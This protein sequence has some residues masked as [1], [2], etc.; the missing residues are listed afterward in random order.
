MSE[1]TL[2]PFTGKLDENIDTNQQ[3]ALKPFTGALDGEK[4]GVMGHLKDTGL[5]ALK[6]AVAVPE[7]AVGIMDVMSDGATGKTLEN[8][9]GTVGFRPKE[10]KQALGDLHTDQYKAQQ[11][12]FADAG[13][14]GSW[15]DKVVDKTKVAL[16]NPSLIT[17][18]V[19]ESVPSMLAGGVLG[20]AS[21]IANPVVAGAV[22]EGAV[23]AGSQA[24]QIRQET[25][26]GRL[27]ADQ[28]L[29]GAT[30][31]VLGG[32]IGFA[33]GRLAQKMGIGDVDTM[34]VTGR[35]GPAEI[36]G[37]IASMPAKSLPRR[38]VEGA[39]SEGFLE[40]L[41][42]SVS[43]QILQ[44]LALDKPWHD[45]IEDAAVMG[46]LA[47]MA[48]GGAANILSGHNTGTET[49]NNQ[50]QSSG[51]PNLPSAPPQL[52][53]SPD[54]A[55]TGEYIPRENVPQGDNQGRTAFVYD[56]PS[57][58][59]DNLL[60]NNYKGDADFDTSGNFD[61]SNNPD[62]PLSPSGGN[63]FEDN[64]TQPQLPSERLGINPDDGPMSS[65]AALAVDS[66]VTPMHSAPQD[67]SQN[68]AP[69]S[70]AIP[71]NYQSL[72]GSNNEKFTP[73]IN[74]L[75]QSAQPSER[76]T[77]NDATNNQGTN[78][79]ESSKNDG[80]TQTTEGT[81]SNTGISVSGVNKTTSAAQGQSNSNNINTVGHDSVLSSEDEAGAT[82]S[83]NIEKNASN[84]KNRT[85]EPIIGADGKNKWFGNQ[86]KAQAFID[87]KKL[88]KDYHVVQDG[89]RF[90]IQPNV[91]QVQD[92]NQSQLE[93]LEQQFVEAKTVPE[94]AK[95]RKEINALQQSVIENTISA[96]ENNISTPKN[97]ILDAQNHI[98]KSQANN[99]ADQLV[100]LEQQFLDAKSVPQKAKL[101]KQ[102]DQ[103]K[104]QQTEIT[105]TPFGSE[106]IQKQY[107]DTAESVMSDIEI[108]GDDFTIDLRDD[109]KKTNALNNSNYN[110]VQK[111]DG[112]VEIVGMKH[113]STGEWVGKKPNAFSIDENAHQAA[114]SSQNNTPEPTQAQIEAG[115]YKK[116]HI[117]VHGLDISI[118]NPKGSE[119][120]GTDPDGKEW[121]H[122]MSDHYGY[123]KRTKGADNEHIDTYIGNNPDS[124]QVFIVD[125]IDQA[126]GNFD[127][128]KV[129]LGFDSQEA[130][131]TAYQSN[132]NQG[133]KVGPIRNM[134]MEQFKDWLKNGDTSKP[135]TDN[136]AN[137]DSQHPVDVWKSEM[138]KAL[139]EAD[140]SHP[141]YKKLQLNLKNG[142]RSA[143]DRESAL[144]QAKEI[145]LNKE[146]STSIPDQFANNKIFTSDAVANA[147]AR[148]KKK[149]GQLNSGI[150]PEVLIDGMT[151]AGAYI[152]SGMR[153]FGDYAKSMVA[154]FG[155]DIKPYLLSFWEG[156]RNYPNLDSNGMTSV[157]QSK[158]EFDA[159]NQTAK[160]SDDMKKV[161]GEQVSRPKNT[162]KPKVDN[163]NRQLVQDWGV[164][165]LDGW[166]TNSEHTG[167][168]Y[169]DYGLKDGVKAA[170]L[171]DTKQYLEAVQKQLEREGYRLH[172]DKKGKPQ[173]ISVNESGTASAGQVT[174]TMLNDGGVSIYVSVSDSAMSSAH[175][176]RIAILFRATTD[177]SNILGSGWNQWAATDLTTS[178]LAQAIDRE[179]QRVLKSS[180]PKLNQGQTDAGIVQT[181]DV[182][183]N[184]TQPTSTDATFS[185]RDSQSVDDG[186]ATTSG[187]L[188]QDG[189]VS[190]SP[191]KSGRT[192]TDSVQQRAESSS[193]TARDSGTLRTG[194]S[195]TV[196]E[197]ELDP[198]TSETS[199]KP[200]LDF[201]L[202]NEEIGKGGLRQ[203]YNDNIATIK[204]LK[205]LESENR[206][207]TPEERKQIAQYVG[208]G[209]LKGVFDKDNKQWSKE[210]TELKSLLTDTE[211]K[212][213]RA[214]VL[215]AHF[216]SKDV[217]NG[218]VSIID[219]L[220]FKSG[221]VLEPSVGTGNF[222]GLMSASLRKKSELHGVELDPITS[223]IV[224]ALYPSAKIAKATG[225]QDFQVP[226]EYFDLVIGNPP[227]GNEP[228]V[229][230]DRSPYSGSSIHNYFFAKSVDK[231]RPGGILAMV[232]SRNFMD[233][234]TNNTRKW[235]A[236]RADLVAAV[237][238]PNTA[239]KENAGTEVVTDIIVLRKRG[240][241]EAANNTQWVETGLQDLTNHKTGETASI[242]VNQYF[243]DNPK[244]ILGEPTANGSMY[245]ANEYTVES[246]NYPLD[247]LLRNWVGTNIP[248]NIYQPV[249]RT[250][251][252]T[253]ANYS[254]P[255][256]VKV[257]SFFM[258][259]QGDVLQRGEDELGSKTAQSWLSPN[260]KAME[261]M[262]GM[263]VLRDTLR[264]QM[265]LEKSL[266][267]DTKQIEANR[268]KLNELYDQFQKNYGYLNNQ[269]NRRIFLDDTESA[270][271][272]ALEFDYDRGVSKLVAEREGTEQRPESATKA[273]IFA[274][275][276]LFPPANNIK[277]HNANDALLASLNYK[278]K[279]DLDYMAGLYDKPVGD[280]VSELG[281][282]VYSD[283]IRGLVMADE[284]LSGDVKTKLDEARAIAKN[285]PEFKRNVDA[286]KKVIPKDK[287]PS[288][289]H[290]T[291]G[292]NFIPVE[293]YQKFTKEVTGADYTF[294]Y[295][296]AT[297]QWIS[298][299]N[300]VPDTALNV[301]KW[302]IEK[303]PATEILTRTMAGQGVVV[304]RTVKMA[305]G[306]TR[307]EVLEKETEAAREK[308][309]ALKV[310][311]QRWLWADPD[312]AE[313][314]ANIYNNK[315]NRIVNRKF[316]GSH[317]TFPGMN[318][319]MALLP[320]QKN[321]VWRILQDRQV[322][323]DH[324]VGAGKTF[325]IVT[326]FME[327]RRLGI[328]RKPFIAVPNHLTLQWR[329]EFNRLYPGSNIL[330]AT[331]DD[332]TKGNRE[333][334]FSKIITG[335]WDAVIVGHSSLK[336]IALPPETEKAVLEEQIHEISSAIEEIKR[337][338]GDRNIIRDMENI[339]ARLENRMKQ[340]IQ[341]LGERD[342][343]VTFD[344][345][346]AD[347]F[348]VDELHEFKNLF[349][350]TTMQ[351]VPGM[352]NP[353]GS[354]K[355]FDLF[356]KLQ[357]MFN[358]FGD[359]NTAAI[360]ATGTPVSNSLVEMF[361]MQRLLQY[362][363]L[364]A[365]DLHIFDAW[366]K[367]FGSVESVYEVSPSG[368]GFRQSNRFSKFKNLPALMALYNSFADTVTL[369]DLKAQE[370]A[371]GKKFPVPKIVG[372]RPQNV[373]A[374][375]SE[376]VA[377]FMG[378]PELEIVAGQP[379]FKFDP[380]NGDTF[381]IVPQDNSGVSLGVLDE[382]GLVKISGIFATEQEARLSLVEYALTP[383]IFV[384][385]K[386]I[387]GQ[388]NN[389]KTLTKVTK[390]KVNALSLTG[391]AN[392][393]GLDYRLIDPNAPDFKDSKINKA[394]AHTIENY[395]KWN[396]DKGTQLIFCDMSIPLSA[397]S[398]FANKERRV[399]VRN[400]G[401]LVHKKGTMH[402][403]EWHED[404]PFFVIKEGSGKDKT[405]FAVYDALSGQR[406]KSGMPSKTMAL[407]QATTLINND[408]S[409]Q[410]WV[411]AIERVGEIE[412]EAIDEYNNEH[413][414][415]AEAT[416]SITRDDIAGSS[417]ATQ[418]SVYDDIKAKL[419]EKGIPEREIAF[420]H[421]YNTP[422][423]KEKLFKAVNKGTVRVL[424]GSTQ[425]MG[426]GT[427]V[428]E[429]L[430]ALHH[431]D[432]P[433]KPSDLEQRE[434][435]IVRRGNKLYE[436]DPDNFEVAIYRYATEQTYD[437]RR[438]QI[439]EHKA[440]GIEQLRN[441]DGTLN[442]ID[443]IEGEAANAADMKAAASGD[444]LI[445]EETQL[446]NEVR[447]LET[448]Q[449]AN[450]DEK[451]ML[452]GRIRQ[453][454]RY[455][456]ETAPNL[457]DEYQSL[458]DTANKHPVPANK[459]DFVGL[460]VG[461][462]TYT[463]RDDAVG[464]I[465]SQLRNAF[466]GQREVIF[467]YRGIPFSLENIAGYVYLNSPTEQMATFDTT[468]D[469]MPSESGMLT[470]FANYIGRLSDYINDVKHKV[471][472]AKKQIES[473]L[474]QLE[475][476]FTQAQ[477][478]INA[479]EAHKRVQRRLIAKGPDIPTHQKPILEKAIDSQ[480][481]ELEKQGL[482]DALKEF[483]GINGKLNNFSRDK[484]KPDNERRG[485]SPLDTTFNA[486]SVVSATRRVLSILQHLKM[487]ATQDASSSGRVNVSLNGSRVNKV[488][489]V[490]TNGFGIQVISS[491][492]DLPKVIQN[493]ATYQDENGKTQNYDVSGVWHNGTLY[494]VADQVY[495]DS[496]KQLTTYDAYE[497]LLAHEIIG[498]FGVQ[499]LFGKEYKT[500]FQQLFNAL[501]GIEGIRKIAKDNGVDMNQFDNSY[502][503][504]FKKGVE[505]GYYDPLDAQQATVSELFAFVA[506]NA[507]ARPFV[508]QKLKEVIGYIRQW[509]RDRGFDKLL[510]RYNDADLMMFLSEAR[511]AVVDRSYFGKYK[512][513]EF[514]SKNDS[515]TPLYSRSTKSSSGSTTQQVREVLIDRFG[516]ETID[517][518][519]RQGKLEII[520]DYQV[521][522][523]E[524]FYYNGKAV[525]IASN[526]T[527]E[528]IVPTFLH[529]LGGH[530][531]F[532][533]MMNQKQY[534]ELMNQ[535]NKL[536]EQGN[537]V[538]M[539]AKLLAEREQGT[540][541]QQLEYLP[542]LLTLSS[543]MQQRNVIQRN[544][545]Q[546]LINNIVSYVKAWVFDNFGIN[547]NLNPDDML[548]LSERMIGQIKHQSSLDLI[549]QK[550]HGTDQ[551]M[552]APNGEKTHLSE[553][554][555]LQVRT[556]EFKKWFGDWEND[557]ANASQV[558]DDNGEPKVVYH[559]TATE[560]NEFKQ[561][562]GLLGDG[563]YLT[564]NFDTADVYANIRG[565]N[566]FVLP[567]FVNIRNAFKTSGNVS[568]DEFVKAT[569][570][571]KY[572]GI[573][574]QF[575]NQEYIVALKPNQVKMAEGNTGTF[576]S[577]SSDIRF[578][579]SAK[580]IIENLSKNLSNISISSVKDKTG[581]KFTDWLGIGLSAL[582]RR[583]LTEIYSK[584]LPQLNKYNELAAQMDADK[585][586]AGAEA[587]SIVR[588]W[589]NLKDE[590][591]L[592][593]L[594][595]DATLAKIDPTKPYVK[596]DSV[597]RYKQLR[598]DYNSL[599]P[600]AQAMYLKARDTYKKHYAKVHQA[601]KERILRSELSS[602]KK[603]DLLKQMDDNFFGYVKGVYFPLARFGKYVVVMRNQNG[604][605]ES[606]SRAE[607]MGEAQS[608]RS[609]LMQKYPHY[610]ID[611]VMLDKEFNASRDA[612]GR[613]FMTNLFAEVDNLG[614][615][616]AEQAEFEDTLSQLYLSSMPDLSWAKHGIHRKGTAGFSQDARRAFA[617]NMFHGAGY[618]AKLR[619]GDQL[620]QQ[621]DDMQKYASEQSKLND[622]YDQPTAQRVIDEMNKRHDNLMN[623]KSHPLSSALTSFGFIY[624]LGLSPAA[625]MVNLSQ[626]ALVAYPI[627]GAKWGFDKAANELLKAS[628]D[629]RKGVEFHK[630]KWEGS[631]T[632][633]YK[634]ISSDIS[635][636]LSKDEKQ[637]YE[638]A[639]ARGVI[640]VTQAHDLAGIAQGED[641]GIMWKTRPI[642]RAASV[643][644]H[645]AERFNREVT[646]I[647][648][649]RLARQSGEKHDSAFDQAV[650]ATYRGHFD[651]SSGNRPRIMQGNVAKV[652]LL[653][654]QFG[655][656]MVYTLARQTYQ[657]IKGETEA[658]RKEARKSLGAILAMHATFAG[659]L[660]LPMVGMLL[661]LASWAGG[662]DD[663]PWDAEIALR[664]YLAEAFGPT[665]STLFM[666]GAP[667]AF[668]PFDMSGRVGINNM[669]LPD[670][671]EGLEG[672]RWA[673]SAMAGALGPVAGI[674]TNLVKGGQDIT[675]GQ[676]LRGI[677]TMLPV[678]L[679][680]FAKTYRYADEGVQDK[681][682][683][684]IMDEVSSMDLLVQGMGFSPSDV[685][686]ANEG[687][688]AIYQLNRKLNE[689]RSRLMT[690]WSRAK[691]MD[692]QQEMD[693][694]W[695]EI[696]GFNDKNPSRRI[697][698]MN[699]NQSYRNRQRRIDRAEDGIYL[700]RNRQ[701]AREAGYFAFGE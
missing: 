673:E 323:L 326:A 2:K 627:M 576:N 679:K 294:R 354:D 124:N 57:M 471:E 254:V 102:I 69:L 683:V 441:Y 35:A 82:S 154:D 684:S 534:N 25:V 698:R 50:Q 188:D 313:N 596:G 299:I 353:K 375:R 103:L 165:Y 217:V 219:R 583:Q 424:L 377:E 360:G 322:L 144:K 220:G 359:D 405:S 176:Q 229:D 604:E 693:E 147:K 479:R 365:N 560:F 310:E 171:K 402:T 541:R 76:N 376:Q 110:A 416:E 600:E 28:S 465:K 318:P 358:T 607:T 290:A 49:Q 656:N 374:K 257:G 587:D 58:E 72:L 105:T 22:G 268:K 523:V 302:G 121:A 233:A 159:L 559:G 606:V 307:T 97:T 295:L 114:T 581:Y 475:Q 519:E 394:V 689:R 14:D 472:D 400:D 236:E 666:K 592:A 511:K 675:E 420:I 552:K 579:R 614:L 277:V 509:F 692:D 270:L 73:S 466:A 237:R 83:F 86:E 533:N 148:L 481:I 586:D 515:D 612:V 203:K 65:A 245:R 341:N 652:L 537:P 695:E 451:Q 662:D 123:I 493:D 133:W 508:R 29:A 106:Q 407:E 296:K 166:A 13:K 522:G 214:S 630:V 317:L 170:F 157:E 261:R 309:A 117:K 429:R 321:A 208:W 145:K 468:R 514:S 646:F 107:G 696:Q 118:E 129:M 551:W 467:N 635:K 141:Q 192:G 131:T 213:A 327:M 387:L 598:D 297:G 644:F 190:G 611:R 336:K 209:A 458:I 680:N 155:E 617:Q 292:A 356:V 372:G 542:Y 158:K 527:T 342:N 626:T 603:A 207:A 609:E 91:V 525:L 167:Q 624:Y 530:A 681:T 262:K 75:D 259:D 414:I 456:N 130:A 637:A 422:S 244:H 620:A 89:K 564:D 677:E 567:L 67:N 84:S 156:A 526:L 314:I 279:V 686:T 426:A 248:E 15:V 47:G 126:S 484:L 172:L 272:Q 505:E 330:A 284:Y 531:G 181:K 601:I 339:K 638:D 345:L 255:D 373:V 503:K 52:G 562:H 572:Q 331:P 361:N 643:M 273:D 645:S 189:R 137:I 242:N 79:G 379:V 300:S 334:F 62:N 239:F 127:E 19:A 46:T 391:L 205:T 101:K 9:D 578:S 200:V 452:R 657:S 651:Y 513:Q 445:L 368:T 594:M 168:I 85:V 199:D 191:E 59:A 253:S 328:A 690:L 566:G 518:L 210:Y 263:I 320:H 618:L 417:G 333:K 249:S 444:P 78:L 349:Y 454:Q 222:F 164:R 363:T 27:T 116:G 409:R 573:V 555:W 31:G 440:R 212:A 134:D 152:E 615:S 139:D 495:G 577:E 92:E 659:T 574:H 140:T 340:R 113:P 286:L 364:K 36:A 60:N 1:S 204:I 184:D 288:E 442:E 434:G 108:L 623:P 43:E 241:D 650:D 602:Q 278:G 283:P 151:I 40:E 247:A 446:R 201:D 413:E 590:N 232:V 425:K 324:V 697:T 100:Q 332:F 658:E 311:W 449:S 412:Q 202:Q 685:R 223:Q 179:A 510:S 312:R 462:K 591:Q 547:L 516:K 221:R 10:A 183:S 298:T 175:P 423:A 88:G 355:A 388:F 556:P 557:A 135:A 195:T 438:W 162:K 281:D 329:S 497:E 599:S 667:R 234:R 561:G 610:K 480:R 366:A 450:V 161:V 613:G 350:N 351:R 642:M 42:Q 193:G 227:F 548:A 460:N 238:L 455:I 70:S 48:M 111:A 112:S 506:Q 271:V 265:R 240:K 6:G 94:K 665:I 653:F 687:K 694:I 517:E 554:Q 660:G 688:T 252:M 32:L 26:D 63:Y 639:V 571:G 243:I 633:L 381:T 16:T 469:K 315:M 226:A 563:I 55:L 439:L 395:Q 553:Q 280:I 173:K 520:Q 371:R 37:E 383:Q 448:L 543:T 408:N 12:E 483:E 589:A 153:K 215:N 304:T 418:F 669:L 682:G 206:V 632:D 344:E 291:L 498:H 457:L 7:L 369:D 436:R 504:P 81:R 194:R 580:D 120:R 287:L 231:L 655:Q 597:S 178:E 568:R 399:Y 316:D 149:L 301:G 343:V 428:Q 415:D 544:A 536:V 187:S 346:G 264:D 478:L 476:P 463:N 256:G 337:D 225:F 150:D 96:S 473:M 397:R 558:L 380:L 595:H 678:F 545:L 98:E 382:S 146:D 80:A 325:E 585:N 401:N 430:V 482:G 224:A 160:L 664:N 538:A 494:V 528:S 540:E 636:F 95:I 260:S 608:L 306:S 45:G 51:T 182:S 23:M 87:K 218:I 582:G 629:F 663:D 392:K 289:I 274:R 30:T 398:G 549:R 486:L 654:K 500:K 491:F 485:T 285:N 196:S 230:N 565:E 197:R 169:T 674:G 447:R 125:Q 163:T 90:E 99:V 648:A 403:V 185:N 488:G 370:I 267:A 421:D 93:A 435:R 3:P 496:R 389:L 305:D 142:L 487:S 622:S 115:N 378:T 699:L 5:S 672:K 507:K 303:M 235:I 276:V 357:W 588:E 180:L 282:A 569:S 404:I 671:Q 393:A 668:T 266:D 464:A 122:T 4:K 470:R 433:W 621:L 443:D 384:D 535:F 628:N 119:R 64:S 529:E 53:S 54:N 691:M 605:V 649:Y 676:T 136:K 20:R 431:I 427:N 335:D 477:D 641:S 521:E 367:Q 308:Q 177:L 319:V 18:T 575:D 453:N 109:N 8:K 17:N 625:A 228:I 539:A 474:Q 251:V 502:I 74:G 670:V 33:G 362:P 38:V 56:Q 132:F 524:G 34:L 385:E 410:S 143:S 61:P 550:Y 174:L 701:D 661:S 258:N 39:I 293:I 432:A 386:S 700:S 411:D 499:K 24:E 216:T 631:K 21:G 437:T 512:N 77:I 584:I 647:A 44:N 352:G 634:T 347:A 198:A 459:D 616:T 246:I 250:D 128:H 619:Y 419:I 275:R 640:D 269:T 186:L 138:S 66:G 348:A 490:N 390:G 593:E 338:R 104:S 11:Q 406:I 461:G 71:S 68:E 41:P 489:D 501:G 570:N 546:K 532:Q 492:S 396:K 211:Y